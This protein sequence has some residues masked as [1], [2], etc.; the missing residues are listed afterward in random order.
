MPRL[1]MLLPSR[2]IKPAAIASEIARA[3]VRGWTSTSRAMSCTLSEHVLSASCRPRRGSRPGLPTQLAEEVG[4][5]GGQ[6]DTCGD[7]LG[8]VGRE[9]ERGVIRVVHASP[10]A[11]RSARAEGGVLAE[12]PLNGDPR[13]TVQ[14][15]TT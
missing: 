14:S 7:T 3:A 13:L 5:P 8:V 1:M 12:P 11:F 15:R 2:S 10:A 4:G 9:I 6:V